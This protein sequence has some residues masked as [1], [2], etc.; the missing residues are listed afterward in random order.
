MKRELSDPRR[1]DGTLVEGDV[2][3]MW[4]EATLMAL[5][6]DVV[7]SALVC[8]IP[9]WFDL[10]L[11]I[12]LTG[13]ADEDA[14]NIISQWAVAGL[15]TPVASG[16]Y[17]FRA[18]IRKRL[19][20]V[21]QSPARRYDFMRLAHILAEQYF[22]SASEQVSRLTGP[23]YDAALRMMD[24]FYPNLEASWE[25]AL[26][27][28]DCDL[29]Y[30]LV[31]VVDPYHSYRHLWAA[32]VE[33]LES[34]VLAC[35]CLHN[36]AHRA[37]MLNSQGV[38]YMHLAAQGQPD[39]LD[40]AIACYKAALAHY[41]PRTTPNDFVMVQNNLGNA[42]MQAKGDPSGNLSSAIRCYDAALR[43]CSFVES[44]LFYAVLHSNRGFAYLALPA[45][46]LLVER[47]ANL[48]RA[49]ESFQAALQVYTPKSAP[50]IYAKLQVGMGSAYAYLLTDETGTIAKSQAS[51]PKH[52]QSMIT[53]YQEALRFY[54]YE[55]APVECAEIYMDLAGAYTLLSREGDADS[56]Q[57]AL[58]AYKAALQY[59]TLESAPE[60][61]AEIQMALGLLYTQLSDGCIAGRSSRYLRRAITCYDE[62]LLVYT[63]D[64]APLLY[65]QLQVHLGIAYARISTEERSKDAQQPF[66]YYQE[67]LKEL[68]DAASATAYADF[69]TYLDTL[70]N[71]LATMDSADSLRQA[72]ACYEASLVVYTVETAPQAY[73]NIQ[74]KLSALYAELHSRVVEPLSCVAVPA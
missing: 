64:H 17:S 70:S 36:G 35:E 40:K 41:T 43:V 11:L 8:A 38:A 1:R 48:Q 59:Y 29:V 60:R 4:L 2:A 30:R 71:R 23:N 15:I 55:A 21:W 3:G 26:A 72:I 73:A 74:D 37:E 10:R 39:A 24:G 56:S 16:G 20:R 19:L 61:Y 45:T 46:D 57:Q 58:A 63:L 32:K 25:A 27:M 13:K 66:V 6:A 22:A 42:Y 69:N 12:L 34:G 5:P 65:A 44:P 31:S 68:S 7:E 62:A 53:C 18:G 50:F 52:L 51:Y 14:D 33:W 49:L 54:T 9:A 47:Q 67:A 28:G